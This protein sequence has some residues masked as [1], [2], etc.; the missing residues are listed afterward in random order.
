MITI[1]APETETISFLSPK[2]ERIIEL[3]L[4]K[5][6]ALMTHYAPYTPM[7]DCNEVFPFPV[8]VDG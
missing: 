2:A 3:L 5:E 8:V 4:G 6:V 1:E 7:P